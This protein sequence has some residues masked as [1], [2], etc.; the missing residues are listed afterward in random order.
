[1]IQF[2]QISMATPV[3]NQRSYVYDFDPE[4]NQALGLSRNPYEV[5]WKADR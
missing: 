2:N 1:M 4:I 5:E 3:S